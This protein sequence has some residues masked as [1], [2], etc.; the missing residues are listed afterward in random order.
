MA[1]KQTVTVHIADTPITTWNWWR[2]VNWLNT[3]F[4][5]GM[6]LYGMIQAL[7]VP[8]QLKTAVWAFAYY[9]MTGM[10]ITAGRC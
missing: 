3:T 9:F 7:W 8:L 5:L 6:P 10:G 4:I 1:S 2:H